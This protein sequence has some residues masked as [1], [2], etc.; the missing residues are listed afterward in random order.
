[1]MML[2]LWS[3]VFI[4]LLWFIDPYINRGSKWQLNNHIWITYIL[5]YDKQYKNG[6]PP[7]GQFKKTHF[8]Q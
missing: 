4:R 8:L 7:F 2:L 1:M 5:Y 3:S 6:L